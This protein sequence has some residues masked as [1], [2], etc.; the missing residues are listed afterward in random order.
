MSARR[1]WIHGG[2]VVDPSQELDGPADVLV[3]DG[4]VA[5]LGPGLERPEDAEAI[6]A[7][8]LVVAPG[9]IDLHVHFREPGGEHKET[10]ATGAMAAVAGGYTTVWTMPNTDPP[11]DDPAA[12][13]YVKA[14][15]EAAGG[16]RVMPIGAAS[17]GMKGEQMTEIGEL[18]AAGAVAVSDDGVP[19]G[20]AGLMRRLLEYTQTFGIAVVQHSEVLELAEGGVMNEG[21]VATALG[22]RGIPNVAEA[23]M[24]ARDALLSELTGGHLHVCHVS[25]RESVEQL[26]LARDK[27]LRVTSEVTPHHLI[28]TEEMVRGYNTE[29]KVNPPLRTA[30]D[31]EAVRR[32]LVDGVIDVIATDHAPHHYEEKER[33]FD[34]APF[35]INGLETAFGLCM[36][37]LV[38]PGHMSL[39]GLVD[40]MSCAPARIMRLDT[41]TLRV[42]A[43]ADIVLLDPDE[44]WRVDPKRFASRSRNTPIAGWE[45]PGRVRRTLVAGE[46]RY[47]V[48]ED[49]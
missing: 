25:A 40:R 27:G 32:A 4:V 1:S 5:A 33:E 37:A 46:T 16:A 10:I 6:D 38:E 7:G 44:R 31:V 9:F 28:L 12:V 29:A 48:E 14:A 30:R 41:G 19:V 47:A 49:G 45:L 13:G 26:R 8:G 17:I 3:E 18:V 20:N 35:G 39:S 15:G 43:P 22:L 23:A 36:K 24:I 2:R 42:G 21:A 11:I 34:D